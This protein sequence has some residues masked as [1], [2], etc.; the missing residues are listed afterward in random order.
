LAIPQQRD[1]E[2]TR[3]RLTEWLDERLDHPPDLAVSDVAIPT[4]GF[5][6][7]TFYLTAT[8]SEDGQ[9]RSERLVTRVQPVAYQALLD[10]DVMTQYRMMA[11]LDAHSVPVARVRWAEDDPAVLGAP[12][13]VMGHVDGR[14]PTS[15]PSYHMGGWVKDLTAVERE[16]MWLSAMDAWTRI[17]RLNWADGFGFLDTGKGVPGLDR[18]L[19]WVER[20]YGWAMQERAR[21][22]TDA[23]LDWV[24]SNRPTPSSVVVSWGDASACNMIYG[25]DLA[26]GAVI[27]FE[28]ASLAPREVDL[29]WWLFWDRF[30]TEG[31]GVPLLDG[32]PSRAD[33]IAHYESLVGEKVRDLEY[34]EVLAALR[35]A[36]ISSKFADMQIEFGLLGKDSTLATNSPVTQILAR[37]LDLPVPDLAPEYK[38]LLERL[39]HGG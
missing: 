22:L 24:L 18:L 23:A 7:E 8:W 21:D 3:K 17:P 33:T 13:F 28:M 37:Y 32:F 39:A 25:D 1:P 10:P 16:R 27:D 19:S 4:M 12:F 30:M 6:S 11:A 20:W 14:C 5:S 34:Y 31:S 36:T 9:S 29:G 2:L 26:V 15:V 35:M 38:A